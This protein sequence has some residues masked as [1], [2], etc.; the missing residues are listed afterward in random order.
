VANGFEDEQSV[1]ASCEYIYSDELSLKEAKVPLRLVAI[2][3]QTIADF[4]K[5]PSIEV[6]YMV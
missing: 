6:L 3:Y 2:I 1:T 5:S 4:R